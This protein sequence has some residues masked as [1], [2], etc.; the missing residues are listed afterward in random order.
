MRYSRL[1]PSLFVTA[2]L[3]VVQIQKASAQSTISIIAQKFTVKIIDTQNPYI[4]GSGVIIKQNGNT[5][6]VITAAHVVK[7][8]E[9]R[10]IAPDKKVYSISKITPLKEIDL[11]IV[12]FKSVE[13]Y[14]LAKISDSDKFPIG[15]NISVAGFPGKTK[16]KDNC[17]FR[18]K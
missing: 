10:I 2:S 8:G 3:V 5:Y 7:R 16:E 15:T 4:S 18:R 1:L 11:A 17:K 14:Q 6:M 13:K 9:Q 12:E